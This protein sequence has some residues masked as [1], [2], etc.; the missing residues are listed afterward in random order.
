MRL[1]LDWTEFVKA[2]SPSPQALEQALHEAKET[3]AA[4][5]TAK[6]SPVR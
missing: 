3:L 1:P 6:V 4:Q 5:L 2:G